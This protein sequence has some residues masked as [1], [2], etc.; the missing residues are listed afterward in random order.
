MISKILFIVLF[1]FC[2]ALSYG[3]IN[4]E[5]DASVSNLLRYGN[6]YEYTGSVRN[7][8]EYFENL[9]DAR[10]NVNGVV[11]GMRYEVSDPIEYGLNFVGVRKR[12]VEYNSD[13]GISLRAGDFWETIS[14]GLSLNSFEDRALGYDTGIDGVRV[15]YNKNFGKKNPFK[16]KAQIL[17][18]NI[19]YSDYLEPE[20][21]ENYKV[22]G[23]YAQI[24]PVKQ[25]TLGMNYMYSIGELPEQNDLT[26]VTSDIPEANLTYTT[27]DF[28]FYISYAHKSSIVSPNSVYTSPVTALGDGLY[29]SV[30]YSFNKLGLTLEYKNYRFD[31]T[32]PD[33]RSSTRPT[34]MLP[35]QNPPTAQKEHTSTLITRN[36]H[37]VDF[38]DEVG[39][40]VDIVYAPNDKMFFNLNGSIA[41]RHYQYMDIDP[42]TNITYQRV[43]R[44]NSF[45]P[46]LDNAFSPFWEVYLEGEYYVSE[47]VYTKL[48]LARQSSVLYN[49]LNPLFSEIIF[50]STIP[51]E[52]KYSFTDKYTLK[53]IG[54]MQW[55]HNS[56][57]VSEDKNYTNQYF[58]L[59]L[60]R[61]PDL[62]V[63]F[64]ADL[65]SDDEEPTGKKSWF[66]G[67]LS[68][69]INQSNT[70]GVSYGTERGGLKCAN[71]ICRY[72]NPFT[73]FR[74]SVATQF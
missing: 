64:S 39:G 3:Q 4:I 61:A 56:I 46:D 23:A 17:G 57:R 48:A 22:R 49:Q 41:S 9:T 31:I 74:L 65:T 2:S 36:P 66:Q 5:A 14:R 60:L 63:T 69:Q 62:T 8:K 44:S 38:N 58:S 16:L 34:R 32:L 7:A 30:S 1:L 40:Q 67:D 29:S 27:T 37:V 59:S 35:Y 42:T 28:Q 51:A 43:E 11:F 13:I 19:K 15:S 70:I 53:I 72:V 47:K 52:F 12:Y 21:I 25:I 33:N 68:Y 10:L 18:G 24:S 26:K 73:G 54:E 6:G 20:R 50:N 55:V 45:L 71:G